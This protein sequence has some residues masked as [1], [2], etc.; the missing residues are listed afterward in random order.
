MYWI[1]RIWYQ[2]EEKL[3]FYNTFQK[4][5]TPLTLGNSSEVELGEFVLTLGSPLSLKNTVTLGVV[6]A[7]D[8]QSGELGLRGKQM[9]YI[10][11]DA[12]IT[13]SFFFII[14]KIIYLGPNLLSYW[15]K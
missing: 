4:N 7:V 14:I 3:N 15:Y 6:S 1:K 12:V 9:K 11:T 2:V 13:V 5:L 8:R 10:Q